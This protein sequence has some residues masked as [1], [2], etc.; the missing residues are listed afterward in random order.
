MK[1]KIRKTNVKKKKQGFRSRMRTTAGRRI[2]AKR[3]R[4]G[5]SKLTSWN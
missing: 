4:R 5:R 3:R 2:L 1:L